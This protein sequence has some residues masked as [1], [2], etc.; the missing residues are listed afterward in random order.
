MAQRDA[1][2]LLHFPFFTIQHTETLF[3]V[4]HLRKVKWPPVSITNTAA[5]LV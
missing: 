2:T 3:G 1:V 4:A 5:Y